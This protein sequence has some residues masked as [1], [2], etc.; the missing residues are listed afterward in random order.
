MD[1]APLNRTNTAITLS[2]EQYERLFF[3]PSA[4]RVGDAAKRFGKINNSIATTYHDLTSHSSQ[5]EFARPTWLPHP[6][7][8]DRTLPM[9]VPGRRSS[10]HPH[11]SHRRLLLLRMHCYDHRR[12]C[13]VRSGKQYVGLIHL[14]DP[15]SKILTIVQ[16]SPSPSSSSMDPTG[17]LLRTTRILCT[18]SHP[19]SRRKAARPARSTSPRRPFTTLQCTFQ[20]RQ[21]ART[22]ESLTK[23]EQVH[24]QLH[25]PH[26]HTPSQ[27]AIRWPVHQPCVLV[28]VDR[29]C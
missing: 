14:G 3:Q 4:P 23:R 12:P 28:R 24:G 18:G 7:H 5:P 1:G 22:T 8:P 6:I 19:H 20:H 29:R 16:H 11:R 25:H 21:V 13:G 2:N 15:N 27:R 9:P 17:V 10:L 26:R